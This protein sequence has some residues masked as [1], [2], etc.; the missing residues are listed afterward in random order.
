MKNNLLNGIN[1]SIQ[2]LEQLKKPS[3]LLFMEEVAHV[4]ASCFENG[5]KVILAGN[6]GSLCDANHF[7]EELTG[8]FK[9]VRPALPAISLSEPGHLTCVGNDLGFDQVF[10]RGV[11]AFGK[12]GD[13]FVGLTTSGN[14]P[15]IINAFDMAKRRG[16]ITV[17][18]LGKNGGQLKGLADFELLIDGFSSSGPIQEAHMTAIHLIIEQIEFLLFPDL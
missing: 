8:V 12:S 18:F 6:G 15:N 14:S 2:A 17:L 4:M 9:K 1:N 13:I 11:E 10:S 7:A 5:N 16:L 3:H